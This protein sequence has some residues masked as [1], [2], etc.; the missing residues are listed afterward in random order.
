MAIVVGTP[1]T[2][3]ATATGNNGTFSY[4]CP[5]NTKM[6]VMGIM[7]EAGT[8]DVANDTTISAVQW[9]GTAMSVA[10]ERN[11][12]GA[13]RAAGIY[14]LVRP[15]AGSYNITFTAT[16][17]L[18]SD[19]QASRLFAV[20]LTGDIGPTIG[21]TDTLLNPNPSITFQV[22]G[23]S[24]VVFDVFMANAEATPGVSQT[25]IINNFDTTKFRAGASYQAHSGSDITNS[26]TGTGAPRYVGA[27]F[28]EGVI[29]LFT[30]Y[31]Q[32]L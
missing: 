20:D 11:G 26:Y 27:E 29:N 10:R 13:G 18:G 19:I 24:G 2:G 5:A 23:T 7:V 14:Y 6:M 8:N 22:Q 9:N 31:I 15:E 4:T 3:A 17:T 21:D 25:A 1:T 28:T 16:P 12:S 30:P 32:I